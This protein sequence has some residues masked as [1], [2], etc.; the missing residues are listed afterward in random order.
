MMELADWRSKGQVIDVLGRAIFT[1]SEMANHR[2]NIILVHGFPTFSYDWAPIWEELSKTYNL[3]ALDMLGFGLSAKPYPH[4]YSIHEQADI[5]IKSARLKG[6]KIVH[7]LAH[8]Y[9]DTVVQEIMARNNEGAL[10]FEIKSVCLLNGGLFPETHNALLIQKLLLSPL[11]PLINKLTRKSN[12]DKSF[13]HVFG[14]ETKPTARQLSEFWDGINENNGRHIFYSLITY[15]RDRRE[16]RSRWVDAIANFTK[17]VA[18][19]NG[20][21]DPVSGHHMVARYIELLGQ[22]AFLREYENIGHYPQLEAP[23][24]VANDYLEFL[25]TL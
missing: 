5:V 16:N 7:I 1:V 18:L 9:G 20:S 14:P 11:G 22:P 2:D 6:L 4:K 13:S 8:D 21:Y 3:F 15:M 25:N 10:P 17:P 19:I 23:E 12:F 24:Q